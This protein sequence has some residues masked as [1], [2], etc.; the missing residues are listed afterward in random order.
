MAV[1]ERLL[2]NVMAH[3][4]ANQ[5]QWNQAEWVIPA[6]DECGTTHCFGGWAYVLGAGIEFNQWASPSGIA[7]MATTFLGLTSEQAVRLFYLTDMYVHEATGERI[8]VDDLWDDVPRADHPLY[9]HAPV[10]YDDF[11]K[12]VHEVT[13]I[14]VEDGVLA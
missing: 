2:R 12:R 1:N 9:R 6:R 4:K 14:N 11:V 8:G 5:E 7:H 10:T 13:G 3:I